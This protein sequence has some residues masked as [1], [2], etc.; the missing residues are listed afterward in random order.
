MS[1]RILSEH[2]FFST[3]PRRRPMTVVKTARPSFGASLFAPP[4]LSVISEIVDGKLYLSGCEPVTGTNLTTRNITAIVCAMTPWE[5]HRTNVIDRTPITM[6]KFRVPVTDS[7]L[8]DLSAY[9]DSV[10]R[11]IDEELKNGGRVLVHCVAGVSRSTS[12]VLAY[13]IRYRGYTLLDAFD[14][15][16]ER[17]KIAWPND[18]FYRQL[19][20]YERSLK[21]KNYPTTVVKVSSS[22]TAGTPENVSN[23]KTLQIPSQQHPHNLDKVVAAG[24]NRPRSPGF[25]R[26]GH[27][28]ILF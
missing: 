17:R 26:G 8:T 10:T 19:I 11:F 15:V 27:G 12:L 7:E 24:S 1:S 16:A 23:H 3:A 22:T 9:F 5:E 4:D 28:P 2:F 13:L 20:S 21:N 25:G 6:K 14:L 18:G